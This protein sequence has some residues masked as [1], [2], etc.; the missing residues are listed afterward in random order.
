MPE[1]WALPGLLDV[2]QLLLT[3]IWNEPF[4]LR[5]FARQLACATDSLG[6][7]P[8]FAL[9]RLFIGAPPLHFTKHAFS[10][11]FLLQD[12]EGLI[13]VVA[14]DEYL[15]WLVSLCYSKR[16]LPERS[17]LVPSRLRRFARKSDATCSKQIST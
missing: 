2:Q 14:A 5:F 9:R 13:N 11:H 4:A 3:R 8:I 12:P 6:L 7:F 15:Q 16:K 1:A 10:L 17:R